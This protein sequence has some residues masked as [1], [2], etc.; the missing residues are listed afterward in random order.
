MK[1]KQVLIA[2]LTVVAFTGCSNNS[3]NNKLQEDAKKAA[4][5]QCRIKQV[6]KAFEA[7]DMSAFD[8]DTKLREQ[9]TLLE[10]KY[11]TDK[12]NF[13]EAVDK[14]M[15]NCKDDKAEEVSSNDSESSSTAVSETNE[16]DD[17]DKMLDDY[18][19][20]TDEYLVLYKKALKGD[21]SAFESYPELME[22]AEDLQKSLEKAEQNKK[23]GMAQLKRMAKI[24]MKML[25]AIQSK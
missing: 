24:Q 17:W 8:G 25:Q 10:K 15:S 16:N 14:E 12:L 22:K 23:L 18:E 19:T 21:N 5:L 4:D 13:L 6:E 7:G 11:E 2:L 20:F 9:L 3:A 1:T